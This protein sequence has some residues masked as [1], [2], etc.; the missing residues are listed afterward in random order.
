[1]PTIPTDSEL[2]RPSKDPLIFPPPYEAIR[3][4]F[5]PHTQWGHDGGQQLLAY[6]TLKDHFPDLSVQDI[7]L[8][9]VTAKRLF[10]SGHSST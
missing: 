4:F 10:A 8:I 9:V 2:R 5:D 7:F 3:P 6:R 1:M